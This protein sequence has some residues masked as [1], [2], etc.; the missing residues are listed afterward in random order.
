MA[1]GKRVGRTLLAQPRGQHQDLHAPALSHCKAD[2]FCSEDP[3]SLCFWAQ[4]WKMAMLVS[5]LIICSNKRWMKELANVKIV[6][7]Q[8]LR[9]V[10]LPMQ[11]L[12]FG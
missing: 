12:V 6:R 9:V 2:W 3:A 8:N 10:R 5:Q 4:F 1:H 7:P 11:A